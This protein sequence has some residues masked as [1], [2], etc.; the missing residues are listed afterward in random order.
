[1]FREVSD[2]DLA[3]RLLSR[4]ILVLESRLQRADACTA[5]RPRCGACQLALST[6]DTSWSY[7]SPLSNCISQFHTPFN[8]AISCSRIFR[9]CLCNRSSPC[10]VQDVSIPSPPG[11]LGTLS[12][13]KT[14]PDTERNTNATSIAPTSMARSLRSSTGG[15]IWPCGWEGT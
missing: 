6:P 12:R 1:M 2:L 3:Q 8:L 7:I 10:G 14:S 5:P 15:P 11:H 13:W 4:V 9:Y